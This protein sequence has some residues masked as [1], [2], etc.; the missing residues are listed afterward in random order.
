[1]TGWE[2]FSPYYAGYPE[3][4]ADKLLTSAKLPLGATV[5]DPWNGSGTTTFVATN[6]GMRS[7]GY[8]INPV[9][10]LVAK[11]RVLASSEADSI[12]PLG[13]QLLRQAKIQHSCYESDDPLLTWFTQETAQHIRLVECAIREALVGTMT[14]SE[15]GPDVSKMSSLASAMYLVLFAVAR[16]LTKPLRS[17]NPT[18]LKAPKYESQKIASS[19]EEI[20]NLFQFH[21]RPLAE[22]INNDPRTY[23]LDCVI[24]DLRIADSTDAA[25]NRGTVDFVLTSPPYCTRICNLIL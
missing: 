16:D 22:A 1:M 2:G 6:M 12:V 5:F 9:M 3:H 15:A 4:F 17:S 18:W 14:I 21:L 25:P 13:T 7:I 20:E 24:S 11:A 23:H 10:V 8:D 19:K